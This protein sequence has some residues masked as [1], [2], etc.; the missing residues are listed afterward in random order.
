MRLKSPSPYKLHYRAGY[1]SVP[2]D[3][4]LARALQSPIAASMQSAS[5]PVTLTTGDPETDKAG[6]IVP[7]SV[8]LPVG[9]LQFLPAE[10]PMERERMDIYVS[11]FDES[12]ERRSAAFSERRQ[13]RLGRSRPE[14][15]L[16]FQNAVL[17]KKGEP[18]R[19]VTAVR[20]QSTEAVGIAEQGGAVLRR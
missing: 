2:S 12:E 19:I 5:L 18:Y 20:D 14:R 8:S 11:V 3:V 15:P 16:R 7:F 13:R 6:V 4:Q 9:K 17:I 1:S 10:K